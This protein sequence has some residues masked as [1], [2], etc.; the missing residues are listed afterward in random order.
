[1]ALS[2]AA[3]DMAV[4]V[5]DEG[6]SFVTK[7]LQGSSEKAFVQAARARFRAVH[8]VKPSASRKESSETY[9][10]ALGYRRA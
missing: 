1:M 8:Y 2:E 9:I 4:K 7:I 6:G 10:V 3:L 5:L